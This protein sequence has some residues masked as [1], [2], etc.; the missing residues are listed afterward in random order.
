M[1]L[2]DL[3]QLAD[4]LVIFSVNTIIIITVNYLLSLL[5]MK[6]Y[7]SIILVVPKNDL[8]GHVHRGAHPRLGT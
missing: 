2:F 6:Q 8:R 1:L 4:Q 3:E 5:L 7:L